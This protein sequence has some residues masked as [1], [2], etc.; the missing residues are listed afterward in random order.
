MGCDKIACFFV[1]WCLFSG[2]KG[3]GVGCEMYLTRAEREMIR[4]EYLLAQ[5]PEAKRIL[6]GLGVAD[7]GQ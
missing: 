4:K 1:D 6:E 7:D 5:V 2:F 3:C